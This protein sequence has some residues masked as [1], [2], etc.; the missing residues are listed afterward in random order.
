MVRDGYIYGLSFL[1]VAGLLKWT[2]GSWAWSIAPVLLAAFFSG[3]S[4]IPGGRFLPAP[5]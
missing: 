5:G 1:A 4:A 2:T 3:F